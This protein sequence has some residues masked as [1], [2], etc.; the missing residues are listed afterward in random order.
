M[1]MRKD[2]LDLREFRKLRVWVKYAPVLSD[3][4]MNIYLLLL[5]LGTSRD[6][7]RI[8]YFF[9]G[10]SF[11]GDFLLYHASK[12]FKLCFLHRVFIIHNFCILFCLYFND[13]IGF[14]II[15][16][17]LRILVFIVGV[18]IHCKLVHQISKGLYD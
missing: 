17:P 3:S 2:N 14:G 5:I 6:L 15:Y 11:L 10:F 16:Y 12:L 8:I 9:C 1:F 18:F 13:T 7:V 4:L